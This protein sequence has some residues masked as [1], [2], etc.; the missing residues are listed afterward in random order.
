MIA[1][2]ILVGSAAVLSQLIDVGQRHAARATEISE[3]QSVCH[4]IMA[5]LLAGIRVW[6]ETRPQ[7][8]DP[9]LPWD[10]TVQIDPLE[11]GDL[12]A[13]TV[14]VTEQQD[15]SRMPTPAGAVAEANQCAFRLVRWVRRP[16]QADSLSGDAGSPPD[17]MRRQ[18][19]LTP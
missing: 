4:N 5:E 10:F 9:F 17:L 18:N 16:V 15:P 3:A 2:S 1:L 12:V 14:T 8:V 19:D 11:I 13:V 7:A 6:E